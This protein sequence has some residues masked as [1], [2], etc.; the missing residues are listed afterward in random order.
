MSRVTR[1]IA[2][3]LEKLIG[4]FYEGPEPPPRL[5]EAVL[6]FR[7]AR[8][9]ASADEWQAMAVRLSEDAWRAA[10]ARGLETLVRDPGRWESP[11]IEGSIGEELPFRTHFAEGDSNDPLRGVAPERRTEMLLVLSKAYSLGYH[12]VSVPDRERKR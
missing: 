8:P 2:E 1:F 11:D 3:K 12:V 4:H 7:A 5:T 6:A 9:D 10:Y